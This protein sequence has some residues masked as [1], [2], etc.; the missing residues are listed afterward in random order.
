MPIK[1]TGPVITLDGVEYTLPPLPLRRMPEVKVLMAGGDP[2]TDPEYIMTLVRA[3]HWS[4]VRNY[5]DLQIEAIQDSID[6]LN[7]SGIVSAF[8]EAN[9]FQAAKSGEAPGS[10]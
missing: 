5:P 8:S 3:V 2:M 1:I 7:Y 9:G 10:Q 4:L 6:L